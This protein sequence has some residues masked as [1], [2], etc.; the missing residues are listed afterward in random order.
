MI[1]PRSHNAPISGKTIDLKAAYKQYAVHPDDRKVLRIGVMDT[2]SSVVK[3]YGANALPFGTTGSV[4]GFLRTSAATWFLGVYGLGLCWGNYF[5]DYPI[6]AAD[7]QTH[8]AE[9]C[10]EGLMNLLGVQFADSG[11]KATRFGK[12]VKALGLVLDLTKFHL[13]EVRICHT[14]QRIGAHS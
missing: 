11:K 6:F 8:E 14:D 13:G 9:S 1:D 7:S 12:E 3:F 2:D 5:D 4:G 10:A